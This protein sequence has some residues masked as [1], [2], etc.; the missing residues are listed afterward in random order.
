[1]L[2]FGSNSELV[3]VVMRVDYGIILTDPLLVGTVSLIT[4]LLLL[5][6]RV[7][8]EGSTLSLVGSAVAAHALGLIGPDI[9]L[10]EGSFLKY[11]ILFNT[12]GELVSLLD[13]QLLP[14]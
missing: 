6:G 1:M 11:L 5:Q 7:V 13:G 3:W 12:G 2:L 8:I 10:Q 9:I 4:V 14:L